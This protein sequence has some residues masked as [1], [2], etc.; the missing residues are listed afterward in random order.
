[1]A[2][3]EKPT[4]CAVECSTTS[5]KCV[6][7]STIQ[8]YTFYCYSN[9]LF[10]CL[11]YIFPPFPVP[12]A[13]INCVWVYNS[14][15]E[16]FGVISDAQLLQFYDTNLNWQLNV[17][18]AQR[19]MEKLRQPSIK[20]F[21]KLYSFIDINYRSCNILQNMSSA[22]NFVCCTIILTNFH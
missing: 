4:Q 7:M 10:C 21:V 6:V 12:N 17:L 13:Y 19:S 15:D 14:Q 18:R 1:M 16:R 9:V 20:S 11:H 2:F 3:N 8:N 22:R 5:F